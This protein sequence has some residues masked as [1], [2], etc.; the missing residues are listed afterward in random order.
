M[1]ERK[2]GA[3]DELICPPNAGAFCRQLSEAK[4]GYIA[5]LPV[6]FFLHL[7]DSWADWFLGFLR[8]GARRGGGSRRKPEATLYRRMGLLK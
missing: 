5:L 1:P 4:G 8:R 2:L 6:A 3:E 7:V